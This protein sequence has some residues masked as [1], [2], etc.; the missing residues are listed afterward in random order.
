MGSHNY[1]NQVGA[2]RA[3]GPSMARTFHTQL[4]V[5][6]VFIKREGIEAKYL[7]DGQRPNCQMYIGNKEHTMDN[8]R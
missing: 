2:V 3:S 4:A 7:S 6:F 5:T 1:V 8:Q